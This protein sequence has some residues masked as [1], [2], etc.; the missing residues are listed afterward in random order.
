MGCMV[1]MSRMVRS[2]RTREWSR[3]EDVLFCY[4]SIIERRL[5]SYVFREMSTEYAGCGWL[6]TFTVLL[7]SA[8]VSHQLLISEDW[9]CGH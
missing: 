9:F 2:P 3:N 4:R 7:A 8:S 5:G 6:S 1:D